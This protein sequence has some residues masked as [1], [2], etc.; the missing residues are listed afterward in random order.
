[1]T[2][3]RLLLLPVLACTLTAAPKASRTAPATLPDVKQW[4]SWRKVAE[5]PPPPEQTRFEGL[6]GS[7]AGALDQNRILV[8]GGSHFPE[9]GPL[10][11]GTRAF[12]DA[13]FVLERRPGPAGGEPVY[14]W[15]P[16]T[17]R[18]PRALA[19]GA[20]VTLEDGVLCCGG[21]DATAC[22][23]D[24]FLL[25]WNGGELEKVDFPPLPK[26]IAFAG[27]ARAG[28]WICVAGG[29]TS[30]GGRSGA[31]F[32]GLDLS[33]PAESRQWQTLPAMPRTALFPV[34][35]GQN[36]GD[37]DC[38]FLFGGRELTSAHDE[39]PFRA[40]LKF[41]FADQK[42]SPVGPIQLP[43]NDR[44]VSVM[45]GAAVPL[46][47][48]RVLILGGDDGEIA[49]LLDANARRTGPAEEVEAY[50]KFNQALLAAHPGYRR[51]ML[52]FHAGTGEWTHAGHFPEGTPA[53]TPAFL[54]DGAVALAGG[55]VSPGR[56]SRAVWLGI[57]EGQ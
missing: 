35:A 19:N 37:S 2:L 40:A 56:R 30:P 21:A 57:L 20:S 54:W 1:M 44:P 52:V 48:Q 31:D 12:T 36:D 14:E 33:Q 27:A 53:I 42:W 9:K 45:G 15:L 43:G 4:V 46:D 18:L 49:R 29:T 55:E 13:V 50:R 10:E 22:H 11:G 6:S 26:P 5:L 16:V 28:D 51:D 41:D 34:C 39:T 23:A 7:F 17:L 32:F 24:V 25:R 8:A 47:N 38:F 3:L